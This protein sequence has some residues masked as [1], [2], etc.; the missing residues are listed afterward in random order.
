MSNNFNKETTPTNIN[1]INSSFNQN[2]VR[3]RIMSQGNSYTTS[4]HTH[5][6]ISTPKPHN[7]PFNV[8]CLFMEN[9]DILIRRIA[10]FLR[11]QNVRFVEQE[12]FTL[13]TLDN[14]TIWI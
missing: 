6:Q 8:K 12:P 11:Q 9:A 5:T 14:H 1:N 10:E 7:G 4:T 3:D 2:N 13:R